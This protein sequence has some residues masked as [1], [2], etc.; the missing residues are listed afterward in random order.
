MDAGNGTIG[1]DNGLGPRGGFRYANS[2]I[3]IGIKGDF[4]FADLKL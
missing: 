2:P 4:S 3:V 1:S